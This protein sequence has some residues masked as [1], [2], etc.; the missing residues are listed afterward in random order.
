M[1]PNT[2]SPYLLDV[3]AMAGATEDQACSHR[4][5]KSS[6]LIG[7]FLLILSWEIYEM[8]VLGADKEWNGR[9]VEAST[10]SIPLLDRIQGTLP[11]EIKHEQDGNGVI[12]NQGKHIDE[13]PL[14]S[15]IPY[16]EGD[17]GVSYRDRLF[18]EIDP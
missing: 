13:F 3:D 7:Y 2:W 1:T 6:G 12:A 15:E 10:L 11:R 8:I 16:R 17:F 14:P 9:F 5:C 4:F 18:H